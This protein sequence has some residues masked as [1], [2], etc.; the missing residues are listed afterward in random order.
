MRTILIPVFIMALVGSACQKR[1]TFSVDA[2]Y[3]YRHLL[4]LIQF[5]VDYPVDL[6]T[7]P[8]TAGQRN[9]TYNY[10]FK[11]DAGG[12]EIESISFGYLSLDSTEQEANM[13]AIIGQ[14][15]ESYIEAG[16]DLSDT[17]T[18]TQE[19]DGKS[20]KMFRCTGTI[21]RPQYDLSG[22]YRV[23]TLILTP[24]YY[25]NGLMI[26]MMARDDSPIQSYEDFAEKGSISVLWQT[27]EIEEPELS[28]EG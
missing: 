11:S 28:P 6:Q 7:M 5:S 17:F 15:E 24:E 26:T 9:Q 3:C 13:E 14:M 4:P 23:Q 27:L 21:D 22:T 12:N 20:L 8:P 16:F 10:F 25:N 18:G 19:F 1:N 2:T